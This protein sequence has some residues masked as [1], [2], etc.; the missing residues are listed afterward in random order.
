MMDELRQ[1]GKA[2]S[3]RGSE[4]V[5]LDQPGSFHQKWVVEVFDTSMP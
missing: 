1:Q 4:M 3:W 5:W 2:P